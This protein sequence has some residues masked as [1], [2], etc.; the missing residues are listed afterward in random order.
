MLIG[1]INLTSNRAGREVMSGNATMVP[2]PFGRKETREYRLPE[3]PEKR[4]KR[5]VLSNSCTPFGLEE[6]NK[7]LPVFGKKGSEL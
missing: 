5:Q 3:N 4:T 2:R 1:G 6:K 7:L